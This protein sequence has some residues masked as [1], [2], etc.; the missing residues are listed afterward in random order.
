MGAATSRREGSAAAA[1]ARLSTE[2]KIL[3]ISLDGA[4]GSTVYVGGMAASEP[5]IRS[6]E[7]ATRELE[8]ALAHLKRLVAIRE[9]RAA[10]I[11]E[12]EAASDSEWA[13]AERVRF[14]VRRHRDLG[15]L[16]R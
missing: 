5:D 6:A 12:L 14:W 16:G 13:A 2:C 11:A 10:S 9:G 1:F 3:N 7:D 8:K 4:H 15:S